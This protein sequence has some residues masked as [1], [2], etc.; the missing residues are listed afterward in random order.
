MATKLIFYF[1]K[2][3]IQE[4]WRQNK[5]VTLKQ[6][7]VKP[8]KEKECMNFF[9]EP[10]QSVGQISTFYITYKKLTDQKTSINIKKH[11]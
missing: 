2:S 5:M 1:L 4:L 9:D 11:Q 6:T 8:L 3:R 7:I 10:F